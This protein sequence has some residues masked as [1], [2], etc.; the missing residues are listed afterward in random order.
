MP[1]L[2]EPIRQRLATE[3]RF[4]ASKVSEAGD[5]STKAYYLSVFFGEPGRQ[6]NMHWDPDLVLMWSVMQ[7][8]CNSIVGRGREATG[9][10]PTGGF[11]DGFAQ[12]MEEISNE[13]AAA[14]E[15]DEVDIPRMYAALA[16]SAELTYATT[17]NGAYLSQRGVIRF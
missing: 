13:L 14:F 16:R 1:R 15:Q 9:A 6:L 4:A 5:I 11:P 3:F 8:L 12:A 17:G 10:F 2:P 7:H